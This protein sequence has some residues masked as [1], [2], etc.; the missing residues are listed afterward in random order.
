[1]PRV[2]RTLSR[3]LSRSMHHLLV[4]AMLLPLAAC[5][6]DSV[7]DVSVP[8]RVREEAL[9]DP[10]L[11]P[12]MVASVISDLECAWNN[13]AAAASL[14]SDEFMQ[15]SGNLNQRNWGSR[16]VTADDPNMATATCRAAYG[17][18]TTLH[19]ARF[20]AEDIFAR[21]DAFTDAQVANRTALKATVRAYGAYALVALGE[22]FCEMVLDGGPIITPTK[23]LEAAEARFTEAITLATTANNQDILNMALV[24]RARVRLDLKNYAGALADARLVPLTYVKNATRD[25][26]DTRRYN[27][28]CE[29]M[30]CPQW[31]HATVAP[32]Y[33]NVTWQG[34]VDPRVQ[35]ATIG[36]LTFDNVQ[37]WYYPSA[38]HRS[39]GYPV[40]LSSGVQA[41][42]FVAEAA[43]RTGD[44]AT[45]RQLINNMHV[46]AG[47]PGYDLTNSETQ[48]QVIA[49]VIEERRRE[50]F[51]EGAFRFNDHLRLT[52]T[53]QEVP[54]KGTPTS[55]L[56]PSGIDG[57][58][59][60]YGTTT[61]FP[62]P[63]VE[64]A[65]NP[66][67]AG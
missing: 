57:T 49:Q 32:A 1:M 38:K 24:G 33:R 20:Q 62:L 61:C 45:A 59:V 13:Y 16:R 60:P 65:N 26:S 12:T 41:R 48:A 18:Y 58:G 64:S 27:A 8:G 51:V 53:P 25:E 3:T 39:R 34:V 11:A 6:L 4:F 31:R 67:T 5:S 21:L 50:M 42:L 55:I 52:G 47:I 2:I 7:L 23:V 56:H 43:A 44:L 35:V 9:A 63:L 15:A 14:M 22:G 66:N 29:F 28:M 17:I 36:T 54:F 10:A 30:A 40:V 37:V 46:A 19:T